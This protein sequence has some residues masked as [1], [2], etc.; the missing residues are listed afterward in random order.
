MSVQESYLEQYRGLKSEILLRMVVVDSRD[1]LPLA[2]EAAI[3]V[4]RERGIEAAPAAPEP[5]QALNDRAADLESGGSSRILWGGV[6]AAIGIGLTIASSGMVMFWG[7][8]ASGVGLMISGSIEKSKA[9]ALRSEA[10]TILTQERD[11][12]A[13]SLSAP[14]ANIGAL[15]PTGSSEKAW[16]GS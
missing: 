1:Y 12:H 4:L 16:P 15:S 14:E 10:H 9:D 7:M 2:I 5:P 8:V 3:M 11:A 6:L 13:G